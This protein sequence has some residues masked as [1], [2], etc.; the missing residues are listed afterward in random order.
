MTANELLKISQ[1]NQIT[2]E[3]IFAQCALDAKVGRTESVFF[4]HFSTEL[5]SDLANKGFRVSERT[6]NVGD[7]I[8]AVS[9]N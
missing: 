6:G 2:T 8:F 9:W 4:T 7:K 5:I 3:A 1:E